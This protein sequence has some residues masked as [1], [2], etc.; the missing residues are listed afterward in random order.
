MQKMMI[1][2]TVKVIHHAVIMARTSFNAI[3]IIPSIKDRVRS[4][5]QDV[6]AIP[7]FGQTIPAMSP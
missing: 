7:R 4:T 3:S 6:T 1:M 2:T 5:H